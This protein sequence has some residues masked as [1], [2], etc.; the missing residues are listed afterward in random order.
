VIRSAAVR[1]QVPAKGESAAWAA[2]VVRRARAKPAI[3]F[4][5]AHLM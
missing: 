1:V 4:R 2:L 5:I 3:V